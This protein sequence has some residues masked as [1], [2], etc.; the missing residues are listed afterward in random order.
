MGAAGSADR[1]MVAFG[2]TPLLIFPGGG[3]QLDGRMYMASTSS[4]TDNRLMPI[5]LHPFPW[6]ARIV[7][8]PSFRYVLGYHN[9][10]LLSYSNRNRSQQ[11]SN[12]RVVQIG[13]PR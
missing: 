9:Q 13:Q 5:H 3:L 7:L 4:E 11:L 8:K 10:I 6:E 2:L 12:F 1:E